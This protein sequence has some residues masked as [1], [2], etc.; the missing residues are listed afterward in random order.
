M[1]I[2]QPVEVIL[3]GDASQ[4][5]PNSGYWILMSYL[6]F[7]SCA[8]CLNFS[9]V[10]NLSWCPHPLCH[11]IHS[12]MNSSCPGNEM[13]TMS[14]TPGLGRRGSLRAQVCLPCRTI[15]PGQVLGA[16]R[17]SRRFF[18]FLLLSPKQLSS[19]AMYTAPTVDQASR[20]NYS[21]LW[22]PEGLSWLNIGS[23]SSGTQEPTPG[24]PRDGCIANL[25][26]K[27]FV[28]LKARP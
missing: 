23:W 10:C 5:P 2:H 22:G 15:E 1:Q 27:L 19:V 9:G 20:V 7:V 14:L 25:K 4:C 12:V 8:P 3:T 17:C 6:D 28:F 18:P 24:T 16:W 11:Y 21:C 13:E 26:L